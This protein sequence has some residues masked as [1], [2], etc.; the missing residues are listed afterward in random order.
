[1]EM[2]HI[3]RE[4]YLHKIEHKIELFSNYNPHCADPRWGFEFFNRVKHDDETNVF[5]LAE[6]PILRCVLATP[7]PTS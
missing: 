6:W 3:P 1:M 7:S 2:H 4:E 5:V